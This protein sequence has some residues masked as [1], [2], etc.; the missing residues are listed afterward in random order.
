MILFPAARQ[1]TIF[2]E[3]LP[4][5][6][7]LEILLCP[8]LNLDDFFTEDVPENNIVELKILSQEISVGTL[9]LIPDKFPSLEKFSINEDCIDESREVWE[10]IVHAAAECGVILD[11]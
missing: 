5:L 7:S 10:A 9:P 8:N 1:L 11:G 6:K 4:S 2:I 3:H